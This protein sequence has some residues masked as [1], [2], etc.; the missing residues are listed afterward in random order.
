ML[1]AVSIVPQKLKLYNL[2]IYSDNK[3]LSAFENPYDAKKY[4]G[5]Y[6]IMWIIGNP[7]KT[8][9]LMRSIICIHYYFSCYIIKLLYFSWCNQNVSGL[10][11]GFVNFSF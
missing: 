7:N 2:F 6:K 4:Y 10:L 1:V 9:D 8:S 5:I 11:L 3:E